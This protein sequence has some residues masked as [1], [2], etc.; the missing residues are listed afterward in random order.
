M[1]LRLPRGV[2]AAMTGST[3]AGVTTAV[4]RDFAIVAGPLQAT[5]RRVGR[6]HAAALAPARVARRRPPGAAP[7]RRARC[8]PTQR[9]FGPYGRD[10]LDLVEGPSAVARGAGLGMEYPELVLTPARAPWSC[11][12]RWRTSG[13]TA[14]SATTS[15]AQPWLDES[16]ASYSGIRL[17][18]RTGG[19]DPPRGQPPLTASMKV[20]GSRGGS[21]D[22]RRVVY[23]GGTCALSTLERGLGRARFDRMMRGVVEEHRDGI[24]T[25]AGFAAAV[26]AA[27]PEGLDAGAL[28]ERSGIV[29]AG[30]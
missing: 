13:G 28:L 17:A 15:T 29:P 8:A 1:R 11:S 12:T 18:G 5:E 30:H 19:C 25:T 23:V 6:R 21:D 10:E 26:R 16:F 7:G 4:A 14:S 3:E 22:Y 9:W 2:R 24:L 20:F 27:A